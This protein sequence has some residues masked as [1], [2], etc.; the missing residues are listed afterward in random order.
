MDFCIG[1]A[2]LLLVDPILWGNQL[3]CQVSGIIPLQG[4]CWIAAATS[5]SIC[6]AAGNNFIPVLAHMLLR[7]GL[8]V[9]NLEYWQPPLSPQLVCCCMPISAQKYIAMCARPCLLWHTGTEQMGYQEKAHLVALLS[10]CMFCEN[11]PASLA[12]SDFMS[13]RAVISRA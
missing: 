7:Q 5:T 13:I 4:Q 8:V 2:M 1:T 9:G 11:S 12:Y 6:S 10:C 3:V